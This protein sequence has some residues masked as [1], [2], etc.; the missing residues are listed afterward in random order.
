MTSSQCPGAASLILADCLD[1]TAAAPLKAQLLAA[2]GAPLSLDASSVRRLGAQCLQ[3]LL[4]AEAAWSGDGLEWRIA[5][6][7]PEFAEAARLMGRPDFAEQDFAEPGLAEADLAE[8]DL[9]EASSAQADL[10][11][12]RPLPAISAH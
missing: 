7:S 2:R 10:L 9:P 5:S 3:V 4:A 11:Q 8:A 1:L 12:A 6:P